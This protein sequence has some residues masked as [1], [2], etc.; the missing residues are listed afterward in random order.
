MS[1]DTVS[2]FAVWFDENARIR[3]K[4]GSRTVPPGLRDYQLA[5]KRSVWYYLRVMGT[6]ARA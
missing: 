5:K 6:E 1:S 2:S 4:Q 3:S